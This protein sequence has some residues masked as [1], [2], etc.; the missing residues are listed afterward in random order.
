[1]IADRLGAG[2][3]WLDVRKYAKL[4]R[5]LS[6]A[7]LPATTYR[8]VVRMISRIV[9]SATTSSNPPIQGFQ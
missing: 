4:T 5:G 1:V 3:A 8:D 7:T 2:D 6:V 9:R